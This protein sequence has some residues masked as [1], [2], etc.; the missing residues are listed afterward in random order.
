MLQ[1]TLLREELEA[2]DPKRWRQ[3]ALGLRGGSIDGAIAQ[4][5]ENS[6]AVNHARGLRRIFDRTSMGWDVRT[7]GG[8]ATSG[9]ANGGVTRYFGAATTGD[10]SVQQRIAGANMSVDVLLGG[11]LVGGTESA[12]AGEYFVYNDATFNVAITASDPANPRIDIVGVQIRDSEYSGGTTD[13][14]IVVV[15]GTPAGMPAEPT[16][17]ANFLT[18]ARVD[19]A[20]AAGSVINANITDRRRMVSA[21]GGVTVCAS[22]AT[23]PTV[24]LWNGQVIYDL[25]LAYPLVRQGGA[26]VEII[27]A[28]T[29][30]TASLTANNITPLGA[31]TAWVMTV[32]SETGALTLVGAIASSWMRVGRFIAW[33]N[34]ITITTNGTGATSLRFTLPVN[35][36]QVTSIG[37][38]RSTAVNANSH[39]VVTY[40]ATGASIV[41]SVGA[42]PA[43]NGWTG[44]F[45]GLYESA[46]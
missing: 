30:F 21:L 9:T 1:D 37:T 16:L 23:Y 11:A 2:L 29:R 4:W 7:L 36:A 38:G 5:E 13:A 22:S 17:P 15:T 39:S 24:N 19:V 44:V 31:W 43:S 42:Y 40:S 41:S 32:T 28:G 20:A 10:L 6:G 35:C 26:W 27:T 33:W 25:A 34:S 45:D 12:H 8:S 14:R 3:V 18:L 46:T